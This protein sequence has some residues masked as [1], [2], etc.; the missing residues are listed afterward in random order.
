MPI[1][2][3]VAQLVI[4]GVRLLVIDYVRGGGAKKVIEAPQ[5][6]PS[7]FTKP[8]EKPTASISQVRERVWSSVGF[9]RTA[10]TVT[11]EQAKAQMLSSATREL[12]AAAALSAHPEIAANP[13][14]LALVDQLAA[15]SNADMT[16]PRTMRDVVAV[17]DGLTRIA[18][19]SITEVIVEEQPAEVATTEDTDDE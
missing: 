9:M 5:I 7:M 8:E 11:D 6:P 3:E 15:L 12:T 4:G 18:Y 2:S 1:P 16:N 17:N 13:E 10:S 14:A 19:G